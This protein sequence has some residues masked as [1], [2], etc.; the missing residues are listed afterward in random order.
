MGLIRLAALWA[1]L[2]AGLVLAQSAPGE[3]FIVLASTTSTEQSGLFAHLL[4]AFSAA[5][6]IGVRVLAL[7][8]GQAL[9]TARRGDADALLVHDRVAEDRFVADGFATQRREVMFNDFVLIGPAADPAGL[10]GTELVAA[11]KKLSTR[12]GTGFVSR[13]DH[14]GTH[15]AEL[16]AWQAAGIDPRALPRSVYQACGCGMGPALNIA[17]STGQ[18]L[19]A[20][21]STWLAFKNRA[22]LAVLVEGDKTLRNHYGVL[23]VDPAKHPHV[24]VALAQQFADWLVSPAGQAR[25]GAYRIHGQPV[26]FPSAKPGE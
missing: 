21:R 2:G 8:T 24:K 5:S 20:D 12:T 1:L 22:D 16:R 15:A 26:F 4:P 25:I 17:A 11:L 23:V 18:Y 10:R 13:G 19:L 3:R 9:D 14:S 6:G 7:G